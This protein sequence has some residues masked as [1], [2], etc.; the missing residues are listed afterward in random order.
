MLDLYRR[1]DCIDCKQTGL[2]NTILHKCPNCGAAEG[3]RDKSKPDQPVIKGFVHG[4]DIHSATAAYMNFFEKYGEDA[5][6]RAKTFNHAA[7]YSMGADTLAKREG[8]PRAEG[9]ENLSGWHRTYP[10]I[11]GNLD[12]PLPGTLHY[13]VAEDI[14]ERG[15]VVMFDGHKRRFHAQQLLQRSGNFHP[16]EWEGTI[17]EGVNVKMQGGTGVLMK[18]AMLM[19]RRELRARSLNDRNYVYVYMVNQVHDE[20]LLEA[21]E[22]IAHDVLKLVCDVMEASAPELDIPVLAEGSTGSNWKAAHA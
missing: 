21:P 6:N 19:L 10:G 20:M 17:R 14:T 12:R 7:T 11:R 5:R 18:R 3:K 15:E 4:K 16:W 22:C 8:I 9:I 1:W 2:S 13:R